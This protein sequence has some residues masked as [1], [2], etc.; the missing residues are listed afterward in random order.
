[1]R[2]VSA[3]EPKWLV[4]VAPSFFKIADQNTISKR[5]KQEKIAPLFDKVRL[6]VFRFS[7]GQGLDADAWVFVLQFAVTQDDWRLS[8]MK[9]ASRSSQT[10]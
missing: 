8:K 10:F 2:E 6:F 3:V 4:E 5:K 1:M 7:F 9:R